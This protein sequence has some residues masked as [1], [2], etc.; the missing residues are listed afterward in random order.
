LT[1]GRKFS[2][3]FFFK[4]KIKF[5]VFFSFRPG[6]IAVMLGLGNTLSNSIWEARMRGVK[7]GPHSSRD[8]KERWIRAKYEHK[9]FLALPSSSGSLGQQLI[10]AVCRSDLKTV[11]LLLAR[12]GPEDV[13]CSVAVRDLRT[14]LHLAAT[15][16]NLALVQLL[17]WVGFY[18]GFPFLC[19]F[20]GQVFNNLYFI[21]V[22][23]LCSITPTSKHWTKKVGR[24]LLLRESAIRPK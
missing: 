20:H 23:C 14:P 11:A 17:L 8:D 1:N 9:E 10:D 7:P 13:N 22:F 4:L 5:F 3:H 6:H 16:G 15:L 18:F 21:L 2:L 24:V 12:A 19:R